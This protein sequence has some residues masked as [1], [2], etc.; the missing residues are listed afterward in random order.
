MNQHSWA[1]LLGLCSRIAVDDHAVKS[2]PEAWESGLMIPLGGKTLGLLGSGKLGTLMAQTGVQRFG[3]KV[4]AWSENLTQEKADAAAE[5]AGLAKGTF[6]VVGKEELFREADVV[7]L[8]LVLSGRSK[9]I[10]G[11]KELGMMKKSAL[12]VNTSRGP[13]VEEGALIEALERGGIQGAALDT[14][15]IEPLP[16]SHPLR[17]NKWGTEGRGEVLL[18]PHMGYVERETL[19]AFYAE[20]AQNLERWLDGKELLNRMV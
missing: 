2:D 10:V 13:L 8:H 12:L 14:Y 18:S 19:D 7:S 15:D 1:L 17:S 16:K 3:M 6:R 4:I 9:G 20:T 5:G 11:E